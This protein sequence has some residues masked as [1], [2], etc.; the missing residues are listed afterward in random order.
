MA[1]LRKCGATV[2]D[3]STMGKG[4][5]D[6]VVGYRDAT[7]L[8]EIKN[9]DRDWKLEETQKKFLSNWNG[10]PVIVMI[11]PEDAPKLLE[12]LTQKENQ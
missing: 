9:P 7:L 8:I 5:P 4:F 12:S 1:A 2:V 3:T 10:G 6:L 11:N